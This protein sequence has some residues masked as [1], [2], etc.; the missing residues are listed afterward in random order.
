[1]SRCRRIQSGIL[2]TLNPKSTCHLPRT[3]HLRVLCTHR[4][5]IRASKSLMSMSPSNLCQIHCNTFTQN[6]SKSSFFRRK[7]FLVNQARPLCSYRPTLACPPIQIIYWIRLLIS[8]WLCPRGL[9]RDL[10][11]PSWMSP[12][13]QLRQL[14][15]TRPSQRRT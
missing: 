8:P 3:N 7:K 6:P 1:M 14:L 11:C 2:P 5:I 13:P 4:Q 15:A 10:S 9:S 12:Y